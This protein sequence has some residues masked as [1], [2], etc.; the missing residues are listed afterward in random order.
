[1]LLISYLNKKKETRTIAFNENNLAEVWYDL[2]Q[3]LDQ[4]AESI[5]ISRKP[6]S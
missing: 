6:S 1:M 5:L 2:Q 3:I 4:G